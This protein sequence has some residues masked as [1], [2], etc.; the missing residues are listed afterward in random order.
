MATM[1]NR[2]TYCYGSEMRRPEIQEHLIRMSQDSPI[3]VANCDGWLRPFVPLANISRKSSTQGESIHE[4]SASFNGLLS[5]SSLVTTK[6][7]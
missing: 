6:R 5:S 1:V 4:K 2:I 3:Y 7:R